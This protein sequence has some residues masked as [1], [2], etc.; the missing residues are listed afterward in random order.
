[1]GLPLA[2]NIQSLRL[3]VALDHVVLFHQILAY[4]SPPLMPLPMMTSFSHPSTHAQ[5]MIA[6]EGS[7][8]IGVQHILPRSGYSPDNLDILFLKQLLKSWMNPST[9]EH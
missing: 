1:M 3:C 5:G 6:L 2:G 8:E 7:G 9:N 4:L